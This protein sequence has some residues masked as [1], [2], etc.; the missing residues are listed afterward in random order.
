MQR[1]VHAPSKPHCL[2]SLFSECT[3]SLYNIQQTHIQQPTAATIGL[4][5]RAAKEAA[6]QNL[7]S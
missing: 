4:A 1:A 5:M 3:L 6:V 7:L 2:V